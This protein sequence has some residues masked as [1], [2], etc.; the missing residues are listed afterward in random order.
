[1][2][3]LP[4]DV[5]AVISYTTRMYHIISFHITFYLLDVYKAFPSTPNRQS[6]KDAY[7]SSYQGRWVTTGSDMHAEQLTAIEGFKLSNHIHDK[8]LKAGLAPRKGLQ[9][10]SWQWTD[11][12]LG[13]RWCDGNTLITAKLV[14]NIVFVAIKSEL[15][16]QL[17]KDGTCVPNAQK[18]YQQIVGD[19]I[20]LGLTS[21]AILHANSAVARKTQCGT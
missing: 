17:I 21:I 7:S 4:Y 16:Y 9:G 11:Y 18:T 20:Y 5:N 2:C 8:H 19:V 1:M 15:G 13:Q 12:T 14:D 6:S 3:H 10:M